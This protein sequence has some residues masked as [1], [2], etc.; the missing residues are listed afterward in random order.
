[1]NV[2]GG[3]GKNKLKQPYYSLK[4]SHINYIFFSTVLKD[5]KAN[6]YKCKIRKTRHSKENMNSYFYSLHFLLEKYI[7]DHTFHKKDS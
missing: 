2:G 4:H 1:M 7:K 3:R 5:I 6:N